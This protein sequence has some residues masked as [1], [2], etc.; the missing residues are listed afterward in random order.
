MGKCLESKQFRIIL[1]G[2][3]V[4]WGKEAIHILSLHNTPHKTEQKPFAEAINSTAFFFPLVFWDALF[5][6]SV[7]VLEEMF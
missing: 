6:A 5:V 7:N 3:K 4:S 2:C 1:Q